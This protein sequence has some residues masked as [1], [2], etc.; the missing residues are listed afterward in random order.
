MRF[1]IMHERTAEMEKGGPPP[2]EV[3]SGV[4]MLMEDAAS[5]GRS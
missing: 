3:M 4:G 1:M 5:V 2:P